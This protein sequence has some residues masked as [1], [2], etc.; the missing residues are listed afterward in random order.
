MK[1]QYSCVKIEIFE[2]EA[3]SVILNSQYGFGCFDNVAED[4]LI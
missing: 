1:K 4:T 3:T 2:V